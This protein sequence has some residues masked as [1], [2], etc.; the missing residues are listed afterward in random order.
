[1]SITRLRRRIAEG[2]EGFTLVELLIV[3]VVV[4]I[5]LAIA[6]P[7]YLGFR[8]RAERTAAAAN[9]RSAVPA[10][11]AYYVTNGDYG[12]A[13]LQPLTLIDQGISRTIV[14]S[15]GP[16]SYCLSETVGRYRARVVGPGGTI[17]VGLAAGSSAVSSCGA[18]G[19]NTGGQNTG[20]QNT[21]GQNG[22]NGQSSDGEDT[23]GRRNDDQNTGEQ[24]GQS[25][26]NQHP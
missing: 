21:G 19:Q 4:S 17:A 20:G 1:M 22:Q 24:T 7:S 16:S 3:L 5:L 18:G 23:G 15:G 10:A 6:V 8:D 11:E 13:D 14:A 26:E 9:V 25:G 2:Q 12:F